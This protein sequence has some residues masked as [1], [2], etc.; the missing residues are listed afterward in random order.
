M[1]VWV[2]VNCRVGHGMGLRCLW[3]IGHGEL[4]MADEGKQKLYAEEIVFLS[5]IES[6]YNSY[7]QHL[8]FRSTICVLQ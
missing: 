4:E 5:Y 6:E 2:L 8:Q 1:V 7:T 3:I